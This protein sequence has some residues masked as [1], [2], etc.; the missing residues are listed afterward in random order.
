MEKKN[1]T[2]AQLC[3][4]WLLTTINNV[5]QALFTSVLGQNFVW[6]FRP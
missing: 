4:L 5:D 3:F 2:V 1:A 6:T